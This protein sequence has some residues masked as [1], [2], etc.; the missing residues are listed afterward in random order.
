VSCDQFPL[1]DAMTKEGNHNS[2]SDAGVGAACAL[3]AI[4]GGWLNV[5]INMSGLKSKKA[6]AAFKK[7]ADELLAKAREEKERIFNTVIKTMG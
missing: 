2:V 1:L 3:A 6:A 4:E 7:E 5:M